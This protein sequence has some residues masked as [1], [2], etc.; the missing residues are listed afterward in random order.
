M[1]NADLRVVITGAGREM[2]RSLAIRYAQS[3]AEVLL[4]AR[5]LD[6]AQNV[7]NELQSLGYTRVNAFHCDLSDPAT[8]RA[9]AQSVENKFGRVDVLINNASPWLEGKALDAAS[10]EDMINVI[11]SCTAGTALMIKHFLPLLRQSSRPDI[12]NI[13]SSSAHPLTHDC[14]GHAAF[15]AAKAGQG[16]LAETLSLRLREEG[17]RVISLYPPKF[18]NSDPLLDGAQ[19]SRTSQD[20]LTSESLIDCI[21]FAVN[22]PRDCFIR[23]FDFESV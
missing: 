20:Q 1:S 17:I 2:G 14:E 4:S 5:D 9:F 21:Q 6:A 3:G 10:D 16:R 12:V 13:V 19:V 18:N 22:M 23:R 11:L 7:C 15:Y 8:I